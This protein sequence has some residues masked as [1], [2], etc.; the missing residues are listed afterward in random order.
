MTVARGIQPPRAP[1]TSGDAVLDIE[2][3]GE[4]G[5]VVETVDIVH[6]LVIYR[7]TTSTRALFYSGQV[8]ESIGAMRGDLKIAT[9]D[10][11][12]ALEITL[13]IDH[14]FVRR[15]V[16]LLTPPQTISVT[17]RRHYPGAIVETIWTGPVTSMAISDTASAPE[18]V[19]RC[20]SFL[21]E[22]LQR[23]LPARTI[24]RL[25]PYTVYDTRCQVDRT[26]VLFH[27]DASVLFV[28]GRTLRYDQGNTSADGW[29]KFG[30]VLV[31][32]GEATGER[33][34]IGTMKYVNLPS[35]VVEIEL[36][37]VVPG[38]KVGDAIT[39]FAGCDLTLETCRNR[40][41]NVVRFGGQPHL[42]TKNPFLAEGFGPPED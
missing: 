14:P 2:T 30:E 20:P 41:D 40:F 7:F 31:T 11:D 15:Y 26:S 38:L 37:T 42:P 29:A 4:I 12:T 16:K 27:V 24:G 9:V 13:P 28:S 33:V 10:G 25:C 17:M 23:P 3:G 35:S 32:G 22:Q 36:H 34:T 18:A 19:F 5:E 39:V 1:G 6:S 8:Y 21:D